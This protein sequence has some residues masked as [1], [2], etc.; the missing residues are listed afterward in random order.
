MQVEEI[1]LPHL[2][3]KSYMKRMAVLFAG[4][5]LLT[6]SCA[7]PKG[8]HYLGFEQVKILNWGFKESVVGFQVKLFNPN[9]YGMQLRQANV[10]IHLNG[11]YLGHSD[12]DTLLPI[13]RN[14]TF[15]VPVKMTVETSSAIQ[16][17]MASARDTA[18]IIKIDGKARI[19]KG[20]MFFNYPIRYE[21]KPNLAQLM[22]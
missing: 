3:V 15:Y 18:V 11:T 5:L 10:D 8:F 7:K 16:G 17:L 13:P 20:G 6:A 12:F 22:K 9:N 14:D 1:N 2:T 19:G 4:L 21:G